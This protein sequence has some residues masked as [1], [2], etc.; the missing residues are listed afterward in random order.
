MAAPAR[1]L[2]RQLGMIPALPMQNQ[3]NGIAELAMISFKTVRRTRFLN[4]GGLLGWSH[5][6][7]TS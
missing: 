5:K 6:R 4:S 7:R 2:Q 1:L 3:A